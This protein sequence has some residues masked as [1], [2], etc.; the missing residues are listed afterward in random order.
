MSTEKKTQDE[1][2][3]RGLPEEEAV[4][5]L[6]AEAGPRPELAEAELDAIRDAARA[7]W[8]RQRAAPAGAAG[9]WRSWA[10][11][12]AAAAL[13]AGLGVVWWTSRGQPPAAPLPPTVASVELTSGVVRVV[14]PGAEGPGE[15]AA[16]LGRSLA[17][18]TEVETGAAP[19]RPG[20]L[21]LRTATGASVR[22]DAGTRI[23]LAAADRIELRHGAV[24][25]DTGGIPGSRGRLAVQSEAGL[26]QDVGTQF[27]V[28]VEGRGPGALTRLRVREGRVELEHAAGRVA[29][30]AGEA[31]VM[32]P[33]SGPVRE[34]VAVYGP[35]WEWVLA[36]APMLEIEGVK[37]RAFL[38]WLAR[39]TGRRI[40]YRD[41]EAASRAES[42]VLHGSIGHLTLAEAPGVV[43]ASAGLG[44]RLADGELEVFV[45]APPGS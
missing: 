14:A 3:W 36:A 24:Y 8:Q 9:R 6:L 19:G 42:I 18:G 15:N 16:A 10:P 17:A 2:L 22:L 31:L 25:V 7:E 40:E 37:V 27:E 33:D 21:A 41:A 29:A 23:K 38:D 1:R 26:F 5:Q 12:A 44:S 39:E 32:R 4:R 35:E 34:S 30:G 28:R 43:L 13:V 11:L 20:R 45:A